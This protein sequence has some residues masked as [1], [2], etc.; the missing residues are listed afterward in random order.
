LQ[1]LFHTHPSSSADTATLLNSY[2]AEQHLLHFGQ[3]DVATCWTLCGLQSGYRSR[4]LGR[5]VYLLE[6]RC[7]GKGDTACH[8]VARTREEWGQERADDLRFYS[9]SSV[10][11]SLDTSVRDVIEALKATE[12]KLGAQQRKL[13]AST[14][15]VEDPDGIVARSSGM[16]RLLGLVRRVSRVDSTLLIT[17]ESGAGKERVARMVH[18]LSPRSSG[19]FIAVNCGAIA[20]S[21]L[22]S[23]LFG[24][25][26]G[27]FT[28]ANSD[29]AGL[30]EAASH[31]TLLL[32]EIGDV[33]PSMQVKLLRVLQEREVRRV[34]E[35]KTRPI[36]VRVIA[37]TN[38][39]LVGDVDDKSFRQDLYYRLK[40]IELHVPPL[41]ERREDILPLARIL[42]AS[43]ALRM[44]RT[45]EGFSPEVADQLQ[46]HAWPGN[47]RELENAMERAAALAGQT[48]VELIDL[49]EDVRS[50]APASPVPLVAEARSLQLIERDHILAALRMNGGNRARTAAQ[51]EIGTAT[52]YRRLK[53]YGMNTSQHG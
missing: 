22:E 46:R 17:G 12:R 35:N 49:P 43:A 20:E 42:L 50:S 39:D 27:A 19:P 10:M 13:V 15:E 38:R 3:S 33:S 34:G 37:A 8:L 41:R 28:G 4:I 30:F 26:R 21:L 6:D 32:D 40:V 53:S 16:R 24:H 25:K 11:E 52:L 14:P 29:R 5:E 45:V 9:A 51:L 23:E 47:V 31:G 7:V 2:E 44:K 18:D 1:G 48:R 36:D